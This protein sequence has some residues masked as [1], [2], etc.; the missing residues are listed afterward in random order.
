MVMS[1][2]QKSFTKI[3]VIVLALLG[4]GAAGDAAGYTP[5]LG[6]LEG[7]AKGLGIGGAALLVAYLHYVWWPVVRGVPAQLSE[8][9]SKLDRILQYVSSGKPVQGAPEADL[10]RAASGP[11]LAFVRPPEGGRVR[12]EV[13]LAF[14]LCGTLAGGLFACGWLKSE[15][16][17]TASDV[18]DCTSANA[19]SLQR[20]FG[21]VVDELITSATNNDGSVDWSRIKQATVGFGVSTGLCVLAHSVQR[22]LVPIQ[23][24]VNAP[25]SSALEPNPAALRAGFAELAG[26]RRFKTE[27]GEL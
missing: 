22:A 14:V 25:K 12:L 8:N 4:G 11:V 17:Q 5:D 26:G 23:K 10:P 21:P 15:T 6:E 7:L 19:R 24:L 3:I 13:I 18:V 2:K 9:S 1:D 16:R 20:Q 27:L